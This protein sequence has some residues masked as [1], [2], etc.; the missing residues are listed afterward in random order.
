LG[1]TIV[2]LTEESIIEIEEIM[3]RIDCPFDFRCYK[4]GF[5]ELCGSPMIDS[6]KLVGCHHKNAAACHFSAPFGSDFLCACPLRMYVAIN[7]G[8]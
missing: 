1:E 2:Q 3:G 8:K 7:Y 5:E 6:G 4:S